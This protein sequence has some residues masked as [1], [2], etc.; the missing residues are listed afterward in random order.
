T[1]VRKKLGSYPSSVTDGTELYN[2]TGTQVNVQD[3]VMYYYSLWSYANETYSSSVNITAGGLIINCYDEE[4]NE[5]LWFDISISNQDGS[6]TYESR[7]NSNG[8]MLNISQLPT[9][10]DIKITVSAASNYS[11]KS[12]VSSWNVD[13][14]YT[15][16]YIVL[17]QVP[18]SKSSTNV[19]CINV[20]N[21]AHSY[22]PFTLDG[23]LITILPD[24]ADDFT[25][26]FVNYTHE[27]Y[28]SRL[29]YRDIDEASFGILNMYLPPTEDKQ[30]YLLEVIDEA[31]NTVSD[32]H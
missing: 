11:G 19:T 28:S 8:L 24:D 5:S 17:S 22:P 31:S 16:T 20:S 10:D 12:E 23:D 30:L 15:I 14:N 21:D 32:A 6:Q 18:D 4:T 7:N 26:I 9:G 27:E 3:M 13:E 2:D 25:K 1:V 29:Y